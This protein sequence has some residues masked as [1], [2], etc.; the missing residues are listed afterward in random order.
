[1]TDIHEL[2][3]TVDTV[4]W[5]KLTNDWEPR[6]QV[7][8][9]DYVKIETLTH[10]AGDA[11][12]LLIDDQIKRIY[13][14][15]EQ[16]ERGPGDHIITGPIY[17]EDAEPGD[18]LEVR[19]LDLE[20]RDP[21]GSNV[22]ANWGELA[23]EFDN[24]EFIN[25]YSADTETGWAV[26]K[27]RYR[28]PGKIKEPGQVRYENEVD[29]ETWSNNVRIPLRLHFGISGVAPKVEEVL[30]STPPHSVGGNVDNQ[31]FGVGTSMY[32]EVQVDGAK[33]YAG[34]SH[35]AQ[36]NGELSGAAIEGSLYGLIQLIV[37]KDKDFKENPL[38]ETPTHWMTHG[39]AKS[40][41]DALHEAALEAM[42]FLTTEKGFE[43]REAYSILSVAGDFHVTQVANGV[44]GVHCKIRKDLFNP[45]D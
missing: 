24:E 19:V 21:H 39:L 8:S 44:K 5:G 34:D 33:Y 27:F 4:H 15:F 25:V 30:D 14:K 36:G 9:G 38:L 11:P 43:R 2:K 1:M 3:A 10:Q 42:H 17:V 6:L 28:Y 12:D 32:Y 35:F 26:P 45:S 7:K 40:L 22:L 13:E 29:R 37:H 23:E 41:D 18:V 31:N 20:P 16:E